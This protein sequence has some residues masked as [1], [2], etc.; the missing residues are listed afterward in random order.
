MSW[1]SRLWQ[2]VR[3]RTNVPVSDRLRP[4]DG[5]HAVPTT[6]RAATQPQRPAAAY[7][8]PERS[9]AW[10]S[11][12]AEAEAAASAGGAPIE[13]PPKPAIPV[14][15][16]APEPIV[17]APEVPASMAMRSETLA[18]PTDLTPPAAGEP[19]ELPD[20]SSI[21]YPDVPG[22]F[23]SPL[24]TRPSLPRRDVGDSRFSTRATAELVAEL[25]V[26]QQRL[27]AVLKR[28]PIVL[29]LPLPGSSPR[30]Y[31]MHAL[32]R[33]FFAD[34]PGHEPR[35]LSLALPAAAESAEGQAADPLDRLELTRLVGLLLESLHDQDHFTSGVV[36]DSFAFC[37]QPRPS[38]ALLRG[39][40]VRRVG[41]DFLP[42]TVPGATTPS[43]DADRH[44]FAQL[45]YQLLVTHGQPTTSAIPGLS[46]AQ[47][48]GAHRL[49][50]R[51][52]GPVGTRPQLG[53]W[54]AVLGS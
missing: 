18:A 47:T 46:D 1:W 51:S 40:H 30:A 45:A 34:S 28:E 9:A 3:G 27:D 2:R 52:A 15:I 22:G 17:A 50:E 7:G 4:W 53:E 41:G 33:E 20:F 13:S 23:A 38:I 42:E 49:W 19:F 24:D 14:V 39:D 48:R 16:A 21:A 10:S 44:G 5:P 8:S 54:L 43:L 36:L 29:S 32:P 12:E 11:A 25:E 31:A 35:T 6:P 26:A 37:L